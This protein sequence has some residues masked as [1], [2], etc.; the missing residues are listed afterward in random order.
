L[1]EERQRAQLRVIRAVIDTLRADG[2]RA[3]LFGG[4]GLDARIG[5]VT[6]E[7]GD[8]EFWVERCDAERSQVVLVRAGATVLMTQPPEEACDYEWDGV[9]FTLPTSIDDLMDDSRPRVGS[10]IGNFQPGRSATT[11]A[12]SMGFRFRRMSVAGMLEMKAQYPRLPNGRRWRAKDIVDIGIL[13][14]LLPE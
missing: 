7:H 10:R 6:R 5:R 3:W 14:K 1:V 9:S 4:W 8:V 12:P 11:R 2:V 13:R